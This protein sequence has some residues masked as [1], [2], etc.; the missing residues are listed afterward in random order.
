MYGRRSRTFG[1]DDPTDRKPRFWNAPQSYTDPEEA[2]T[3]DVWSHCARI[4]AICNFDRALRANL[5]QAPVTDNVNGIFV[6]H[7]RATATLSLSSSTIADYF[8]FSIRYPVAGMMIS[9]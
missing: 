8:A 7:A 9:P 4:I 2:M 5:Y 3:D 1:T 6:S